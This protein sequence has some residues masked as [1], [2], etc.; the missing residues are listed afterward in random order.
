MAAA[1]CSQLPHKLKPNSVILHRLLLHQSNPKQA[2]HIPVILGPAH[3]RYRRSRQLS[4]P[5]SPPNRPHSGLNFVSKHV[6]L[7]I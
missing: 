2:A 7:K 5:Q 1:H 6:P 4:P 3:L